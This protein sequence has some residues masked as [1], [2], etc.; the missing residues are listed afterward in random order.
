MICRSRCRRFIT[1]LSVQYLLSLYEKERIGLHYLEWD[2]LFAQASGVISTSVKQSVSV[3]SLSGTLLATKAEQCH[4]MNCKW[5]TSYK[6][7]SEVSE[8]AKQRKCT[9][10]SRSAAGRRKW[11]DRRGTSPATWSPTESITARI[12]QT[13]I[14]LLVCMV[15]I[16]THTVSSVYNRNISNCN[17]EIHRFTVK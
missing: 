3:H 7:D 9:K 5:Q 8:C 6:H 12:F 2:C 1:T 4:T 16:M 14:F 15:I 17:T 10:I 13:V 11:E